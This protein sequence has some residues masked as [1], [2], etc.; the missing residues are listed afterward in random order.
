MSNGEKIIEANGVDLCVQTFGKPDDPAILLIHGA[1]ASMLWWEAELCERLAAAGRYVIRF[2]NR[3]TGHS[4]NYPPGRPEYSLPDMA[5]DAIGIL[6]ALGVDRA[7]LVGRSMAGAIAL[8]AADRYADR[9]ASLTLVSTTTGDHDLP[10]MSSD[11]IEYTSSGGPNPEDHEAVVEFIVGLQQRYSGPSVYFDEN[12]ARALAE[13]DVDRTDNVAACLVNH[14]VIDTGSRIDF[15]SVAKPTL[16]VHGELDPI[17][18][19]EHGQALQKAIP[20]ANLLVLEKA[21]HEVPPQTWDV[22]VAALVEH[23]AG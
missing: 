14:F 11:F 15:G 22:F 2:D 16:V 4:T 7:H 18:P 3:D 17:F 13:A 6:D 1:S 12:A 20:G 10:P 23:T 8:V 19:V 9:V 21:G 5:T